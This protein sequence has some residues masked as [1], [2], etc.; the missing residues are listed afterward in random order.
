MGVSVIVVTR[1]QLYDIPALEAIAMSIYRAAGRRFRY[2]FDG[3]RERQ[4]N[5]LNGLRMG[6]GLPLV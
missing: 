6:T 3:Y 4:Q 5:L 1:E 2:R